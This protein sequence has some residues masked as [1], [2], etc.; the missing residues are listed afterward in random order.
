VDGHSTDR[1]LE[2]AKRY[3]DKIV[4][5]NKR[6]ISDARNI[7]WK[8]AS[9]DIVAYCDADCKPPKDWIEKIIL[10]FKKTNAFGV[11]GPFNAYD[12]SF[13]LR[14]TIKIWADWLPTFLAWFFNYHNCW[15]M[16][17]AFKKNILKKFPFRHKF[18][19]DYDIGMRLRAIGK[20]KFVKKLGLT[21]SSRRFK[22]V[23]GFYKICLIDYIFYTLKA[24]ITG[25]RDAGYFQ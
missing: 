17:M 8:I 10:Q 12:G 1:T 7:G 15:G 21:A 20:M 25:K 6:G 19:E 22:T 3:A 4:K 23:L 11:S 13:L 24:K 16:N 5:D 14:W 2:I 18:L 9:G